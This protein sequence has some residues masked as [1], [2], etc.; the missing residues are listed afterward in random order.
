MLKQILNDMQTMDI[1][2]WY[3]GQKPLYGKE[4][5]SYWET[6]GHF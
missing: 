2:A 4:W 1:N 3:F 6:Q 5:K